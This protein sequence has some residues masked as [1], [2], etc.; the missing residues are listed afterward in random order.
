MHSK[1]FTGEILCDLRTRAIEC[2]TQLSG[3]V[4][5]GLNMGQ[6]ILASDAFDKV[7]S[8]EQLCRL[9]TR[10][11]NKKSATGLAKPFRKRLEC[12]HASRIKRRHVAKPQ[13]NDWRKVF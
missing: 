2:R 10:S 12:M 8:R 13:N 9:V 7:G 11:A 5:S 1:R 3:A 6:E 4:E